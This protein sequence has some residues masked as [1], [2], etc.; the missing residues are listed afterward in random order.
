MT[1]LIAGIAGPYLLVSGLGFIFSSNFYTRM[2][3][4]AADSDPILVNLSGAVHFII[5]MVILVNHWMWGSA[6]EITVSLLGIAAGV[7]GFILIVAPELTLKSSDGTAKL[8]KLMGTLFIAVGG[9]F[10]YIGYFA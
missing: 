7:K 6:T 5:G 1:E 10:I 2:I 9:Y 8:L 4:E 3:E